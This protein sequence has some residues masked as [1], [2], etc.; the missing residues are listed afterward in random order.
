MTTGIKLPPGHSVQIYR[1]G[2]QTQCFKIVSYCEF[3]DE[4]GKVHNQQDVFGR[5]FTR[6]DVVDPVTGATVQYK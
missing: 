3:K 1:T 2:E 6:V 4:E 5:S